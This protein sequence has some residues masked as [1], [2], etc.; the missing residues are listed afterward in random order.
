MEEIKESK[1][2]VKKQGFFKYVFNFD[3]DSKGSMLNLIQ[4]SVLAFV[5]VV[6]LNKSMQRFVPEVDDHKSSLELLVEVVIQIIVMVLG[7]FYI[8]RIITFIPTYS[9]QKYPEYNVIVTVLPILLIT[10]SLQTKLGE[11]VS[12]LCDRLYDAWEGNDKKKK[13]KQ[14]QQQQQQN[15]IRVSQP[16]S[17]NFNDSSHQQQQQQQQYGGGTTSISSLPG[18]QGPPVF[19]SFYQ[20]N[21]EQPIMAANEFI[22]GY[23]GFGSGL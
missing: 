8:H 18:Q 11:K 23:G 9:E 12:I 2:E 4:F 10:L 14:Q 7:V 3:E 21:N 17:E 5:P 16:L 19:D 1:D 13:K 22:G 20:Q 15:Q 6:I